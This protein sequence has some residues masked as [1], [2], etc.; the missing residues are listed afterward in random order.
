MLEKSVLTILELTKNQH[1]GHKKTKLNIK[2]CH[3]M[4]TSSTHLQNWSFHV[5]ERMRTSTKSQKMHVQSMQKYCFFI[6]RYAHLWGFCCRRRRGSL[7]FL[8]VIIIISNR[9]LEVEF[10]LTVSFNASF[11]TVSSVSTK[12]GLLIFFQ[13]NHK[14]PPLKSAEKLKRKEERVNMFFPRV[15]LF[16]K[17][18]CSNS[19][20]VTQKEVKNSS[21]FLFFRIERKKG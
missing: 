20:T 16:L 7:S 6:V 12:A 1:L 3:R 11:S 2:F 17:L 14:S 9:N 21:F 5:V 19:A 15:F 8:M 10:E 13:I 18:V 4:F